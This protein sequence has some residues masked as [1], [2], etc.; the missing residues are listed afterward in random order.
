MNFDNCDFSS[1][2]GPICPYCEYQHIANDI[3]YYVQKP[4]E[5]VCHNCN[6]R[7]VMVGNVEWSWETVRIEEKNIL[8]KHDDTMFRCTV[9]GKIGTVGRC[10]GMDTREPLNYLAL[11]EIEEE[12][13]KKFFKNEI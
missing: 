6:K 13:F 8:V 5:F 10:C 9:C 1:E 7:F 11:L 12:E 3:D 2:V 4:K